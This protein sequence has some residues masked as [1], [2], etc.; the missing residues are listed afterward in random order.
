MLKTILKLLYVRYKDTFMD[1]VVSDFILETP[2]DVQEPAMTFLAGG[3]VK[4]EKWVFSQSHFLQRRG[5]ND[6]ANAQL[7]QGA[8]LYLK[9]L[10]TLVNQ[11][12]PMVGMIETSEPRAMREKVE[13]GAVVD[14]F[15]S[16]MK[17]YNENRKNIGDK[18]NDDKIAKVE[19]H[20]GA[21]SRRNED[22]NG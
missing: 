22:S 13:T 6:I 10:Y 18:A 20:K 11:H 16:N 21:K 4:M 5:I 9:I 14:E 17:Q 8:L 12:K 1:F 19:K 7:Y 2:L 15:I 3:R